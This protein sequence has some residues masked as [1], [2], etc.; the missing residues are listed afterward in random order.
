MNPWDALSPAEHAGITYR[1]A[2]AQSFHIMAGQNAGLASA[3]EFC[4]KNSNQ[5]GAV[6]SYNSEQA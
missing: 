4:R 1:A 5:R 3:A 6:N 2:C